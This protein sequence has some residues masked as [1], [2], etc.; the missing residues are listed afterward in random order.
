MVIPDL[1]AT[2]L[3]FVTA[4]VFALV[5]ERFIKLP[6]PLW[7]IIMGFLY[8]LTLPSTGWDT[9]VRYDNFEDL[10]MY[11]LLP[12]II[13]EATLNIDGAAFRRYLPII[14]MLAFP[15]LILA[16]VTG[17]YLIYFGIGHP[18]GFPLVAAF[19]TATIFAATE[20]SV[21]VNQLQR[22]SSS[23]GLGTILEGESLFNDASAI[24]L[25]T[26]LVS[27]ALGAQET[28]A[29]GA[30]LNFMMV[31]FGGIAIGFG[32]GV[33][34]SL[35]QKLLGNHPV[36]HGFMTIG[37]AYG[38]FFVTE[39]FFDFSGVMAVLFAAIVYRRTMR[40]SKT[41][42]TAAVRYI[43]QLLAFIASIL[44][45]VLL[46]LV[47]TIDMFT[48]RWLA[49]LIG[50]GAAL[51]A[52]LVSVYALSF[53]CHLIGQSINNKYPPLLFWG[54]HRGAVSIALVLSLPVEL[55]YWW[56]IQSMGFGA[57]LF[58]M[59]FQATSTSSLLRLLKLHK[60]K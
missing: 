17:G 39:F 18:V 31:F 49:M 53:A 58:S 42:H 25:F 50:I 7:L 35:V 10:M 34:A 56:T 3:M 54:G 26:V 20:S 45:F 4:G 15:G 46:G 27:I 21:I 33:A 22:Y 48:E 23:S 29:Q 13:F 51:F 11:V 9:G 32:T 57:V 28:S 19:I 60:T 59:V 40:K 55:D 6:L 43:W 24:V 12:V 38:S 16:T 37:L 1:V 30:M 41:R 5:A 47:I 14:T 2:V 36:I 52:R 8:S 44:V